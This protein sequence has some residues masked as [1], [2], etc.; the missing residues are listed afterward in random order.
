MADEVLDLRL[1]GE[2]VVGELAL[3]LAPGT[4]AGPQD[5]KLDAVLADGL[6]NLAASVNCVLGASPSA[7]A[8]PM[9]KHE[10]GRARFLVHGRVE[11]DRLVPVKNAGRLPPPPSSSRPGKKR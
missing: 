5:L 8:K 7:F 4:K 6:T 2:R 9:G 3:D 10:D 1:E 11:G